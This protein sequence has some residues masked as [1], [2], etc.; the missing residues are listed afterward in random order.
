MTHAAAR[1]EQLRGAKDL[2]QGL[3]M[4]Y[5]CEQRPDAALDVFGAGLR[6]HG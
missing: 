2:P 6:E 4:G 5:N 1:S 3:A